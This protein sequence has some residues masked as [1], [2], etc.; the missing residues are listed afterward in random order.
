MANT[1]PG[2][3]A[4][5]SCS[6]DSELCNS[7][8]S[9]VP[10]YQRELAR[11]ELVGAGT[12]NRSVA[13]QSQ[14]VK[15]LEAELAE[16]LWPSA[17]GR[18]ILLYRVLVNKVKRLLQRHNNELGIVLSTG[19]TIAQ[20]EHM[21]TFLAVSRENRNRK[22]KRLL[23]ARGT[24]LYMARALPH[25]IFSAMGMT[26]FKIDPTC[27]NDVSEMLRVEEVR[28]AYGRCA[29]AKVNSLV[30]RTSEG[31]EIG[32]GAFGNDA[33]NAKVRWS[34]EAVHLSMDT[35]FSD[36]RINR[37]TF[38]LIL[39]T[40]LRATLQVRNAT[41][42]SPCTCGPANPEIYLMAVV[43]AEHPHIFDLMASIL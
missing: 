12:S 38:R 5:T 28:K 17:S 25:H 22:S 42:C 6:E 20:Y 4:S 32:N 14:H 29:V 31:H 40:Y 2:D 26:R 24:L 13:N 21:M 1:E 11:T 37:T 27:T 23:L 9:E 8:K 19:P 36:V 41:T 35:Q 3:T 10:R 7:N 30:K 39:L 15:R 34:R 18:S 33:C 43:V 16:T